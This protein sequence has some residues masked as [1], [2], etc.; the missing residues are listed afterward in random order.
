M[1]I[2][3]VNYYSL[4][5]LGDA[6]ILNVQIAELL[7]DFPD[8]EITVST[9]EKINRIPVEERDKFISSFFHQAIYKNNNPILRLLNTFYVLL[10]SMFWLMMFK[11]LHTN[12]SLILSKD[13][14]SIIEKYKSADMIISVG[15]GYINAKSGWR[16]TLSLILLLH[17]IYFAKQLGKPVYLLSQSFGP[18]SNKFQVTMTSLILKNAD[19]LFVRENES[20]AFLNNIKID[21]SKI[22]RTI[23]SAFLYKSNDKNEAKVYMH[24][25]GINFKYPVIGITVRRWFED[26]KQLKFENEVRLFIEKLLKNKNNIQIILIPQSIDAD[27]NDDDRNINENIYSKL[28][29]RK[30]VFLISEQISLSMTKSI[31]ENLSVLIGTRMHSCIFALSGKIPVIA[32]EYEYKTRGIMNDLGLSEWVI[33]IE[34]VTAQDLEKKYHKLEIYRDVYLK[35]INK[36]LPLYIGKS[37]SLKLALTD[38]TYNIAKS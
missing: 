31:Y 27:H 8:A 11:Y 33:K 21:S 16:S 17:P 12:N 37:I 1:K 4:S 32:I 24:N 19:H 5:N 30:N 10:A 7:R 36:E 15:G 25:L 26:K 34:D 22:T 3:I 6:A 2:L 35:K 28:T 29:N 20:L 18:M 23:D 13:L 38:D 9:L 14:K